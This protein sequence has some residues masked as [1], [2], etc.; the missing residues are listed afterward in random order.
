MKALIAMNGRNVR[1]IVEDSL[2]RLGEHSELLIV[3]RE[4]DSLSNDIKTGVQGTP[5][6]IITWIRSNPGCEYSLICN[7]GTSAQLIPVLLELTSYE[8]LEG[9]VGG[10]I[11]IYITNIYDIQQEGKTQFEFPVR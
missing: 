7:G 4:G 2:L 3:K 8:K 11:P 9:V 5:E 1:N 6:E 10:M